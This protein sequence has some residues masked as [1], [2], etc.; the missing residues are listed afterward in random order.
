M[1]VF[2]RNTEEYVNVVRRD[3]NKI[4]S[5]ISIRIILKGLSI[6]VGWELDPFRGFEFCIGFEA[7]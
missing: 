3:L 4:P 5:S 1:F 2:V 7:Q 6:F